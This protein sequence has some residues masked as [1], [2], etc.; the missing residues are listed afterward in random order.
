MSVTDEAPAGHVG[1]ALR[2]KEDPRLITGQGRYVDDISLPGMLWASFV[3]SPEAH[4]KIVSIDTSAAAARDGITAVFTG[5]DMSDLGGPLPM[6]WVPPGVEVN[7]PEH[8]PLAKG[9]VNHVGDP[10]AVVIGEDRY[11]G[12]DAAEDVLVEYE[13]LPVDRRPRG[14]ASPGRRS[15]TSSSAPTRSTSGRWPAATSRQVS[16]RPT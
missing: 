10:V 8:W 5:E 13:S 7:N 16:P 4:A 2:R 3:R 11:A 14:G 12:Q 9:A 1:R 15:C 6:A